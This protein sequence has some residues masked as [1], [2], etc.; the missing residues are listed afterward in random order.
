MTRQ[1]KTN[2]KQAVSQPRDVEPTY[3]IDDIVSQLD[4]LGERYEVVIGSLVP[5]GK[6]RFTR[7]EVLALIRK[8]KTKE[9][10]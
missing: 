3:T 10:K 1:A 6:E 5:T 7:S 2:E 9:V 8:F 4:S